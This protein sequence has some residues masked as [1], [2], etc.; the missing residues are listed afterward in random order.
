MIKKELRMKATLL[1]AVAA[2]A[3]LVVSAPD[4]HADVITDWNLKTGQILGEAKLGT[5]PAVRVIALVQTAASEAVQRR[6]GSAEAA[7]AAA[8]R[9]TLLALVPSQ[10]DAIEQAYQAALA[11]VAEGPAKAAGIAAGEK[12]AAAVLAARADD[13]VAGP[14][15]YRPHAAAGAYV[16]TA[17]VAATPWPRRKPWLMASAAQLRPA[18]PPALSSDTWTRDY[19]EIKALG[20]RAGSQRNAE[21]TEVAKFWDYS[22]PPIYFGVVR[23]VAQA[24]GRDVERNARLYAAVA[25]AMDDALISVF[26]AKY[27]YNFWRPVTAIRNGDQDGNDQTARDAAWT[28]LVDNPMHPEYPSGHSIL[29]SA[30]GAV[31]KADLGKGPVPVMSTTSPTAPGVTRRWTQV[32]DFVREVSDARVWGGLHFRF[33]TDVSNVMGRQI[34]EMAA[35][36]VLAPQH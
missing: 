6:T 14:D 29:A 28:P 31:I 34:G 19:N 25:Q 36:K 17:A 2:A 24:A 12:A 22:L 21:Q 1:H 10:K 35:S 9:A 30:V 13:S 26:E 33:T 4:A 5:P 16:P 32:D 23:S 15:T 3:F 18:A 20:G 11:P 7:V 27:T 8:H